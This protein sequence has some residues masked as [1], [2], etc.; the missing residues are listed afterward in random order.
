[1]RENHAKCVTLDRPGVV[2][3][4]NVV[5]QQTCL[6]MKSIRWSSR[7]NKSQETSRIF[8][9]FSGN[10]TTIVMSAEVIDIS[11]RHSHFAFLQ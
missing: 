11:E 6:K 1:M 10:K 4:D 5:L 9:K 8:Y 2:G 3:K 7:T